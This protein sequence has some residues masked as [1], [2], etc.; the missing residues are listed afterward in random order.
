[1][2]LPEKGDFANEFNTLGYKKLCCKY[3][4]CIAEGVKGPGSSTV[5]F[6]ICNGNPGKNDAVCK[7][8]YL[9]LIPNG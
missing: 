7:S 1:M 9:A 8:R 6:C 5:G 2:Y 3:E 4:F